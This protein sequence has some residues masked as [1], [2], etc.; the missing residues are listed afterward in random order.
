[1]KFHPEK[2]QVITISRRRKNIYHD[3]TLHG[4]SLEH[5]K[6]VKYLGL[7]ITQDLRWN[8]HVNNITSK[9][10][11]TLSFLKRNLQVNNPRLKTTAYHTLVRPQL[12]YACTVWDPFTKSNTERIEEVQRRAARYTLNRYNNTSSVS[13]M[14]K[15]LNWASL[16][17]RRKIH[18]LMMM[19][20]MTW[21]CR[22]R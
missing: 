7:T 10:N 14:T 18:R 12:E 20:K 8:K 11:N 4:H 19:Y 6:S 16:E 15:E 9:A 13:K 3:Y 17:E 5:V 22:T 21:S 2:C 1:M